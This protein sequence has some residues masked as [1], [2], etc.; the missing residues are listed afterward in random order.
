MVIISCLGLPEKRRICSKNI[1][2]KTEKTRSKAG[3][4]EI[5]RPVSES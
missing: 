3:G 4:R 1:K 2:S 5:Q